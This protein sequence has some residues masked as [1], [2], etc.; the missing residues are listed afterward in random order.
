MNDIVT[1]RSIMTALGRQLTAAV[2]KQSVAASNLANIDTPGY[3]TRE[4]SFD[5]ALSRELS[6]A[7][8][9]AA[10]QPGHSLVAICSSGALVM[11]AS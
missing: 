7:P 6:S 4:V 9:L 3:R 10:T 2:A 11:T 8:P 5:D 1:D